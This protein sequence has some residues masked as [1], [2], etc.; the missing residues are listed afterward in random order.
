MTDKPDDIDNIVQPVLFFDFLLKGKDNS[1]VTSSAH[2][3]KLIFS[4]S[5]SL[6]PSF[7]IEL[8]L[9][10]N[11]VESLEHINANIK[12]MPFPAAQ[13]YRSSN[14]ATTSNSDNNN[15][16]GSMLAMVA[17]SILFC[18]NEERTA[19]ELSQL[20]PIERQQVWADMT[21]HVETNNYRIRVED[22]NVE[23]VTQRIQELKQ[24]LYRLITTTST[25]SSSTLPDEQQ[26]EQQYQGSSIPSSTTP[27]A[28]HLALQTNIYYVLHDRFL[29][30]FLRSENFHVG[31][32]AKRMA[33][34]FQCKLELFGLERL[35]QN[36]TLSDL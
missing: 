9:H 23:F 12:T 33:C 2:H 21:G 28:L 20:H 1:L 13:E 30:A 5:L 18:P 11:K 29:L 15:N 25:S 17:Q 36:I 35:C 31:N 8:V 10:A 26:Q 6:A 14:Y 19:R 7:W 24:E 32:A 16:E 3:C 34:H 27:D 4:L 22:E